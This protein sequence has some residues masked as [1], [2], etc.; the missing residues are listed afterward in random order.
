VKFL[1]TLD[2]KTVCAGSK[3]NFDIFC[4]EIFL[5]KESERENAK[6]EVNKRAL[7]IR[8]FLVKSNI[9]FFCE[10][11]DKSPNSSRVEDL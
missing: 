2:Q 1:I 6:V 11:I 4:D 5:E 8:L 3:L 9:A 10:G 7:R